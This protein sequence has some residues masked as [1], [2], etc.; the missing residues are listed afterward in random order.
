MKVSRSGYYGWLDRPESNRSIK[1]K[2]LTKVI[3]EIFIYNIA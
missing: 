3:K 2:E 1:N